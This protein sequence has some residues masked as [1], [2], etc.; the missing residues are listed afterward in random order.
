MH[1]AAGARKGAD[2][3][4]ALQRIVCPVDFSDCSRRALEHAAALARASY[5]ELIVLHV[6]SVLSVEDLLPLSNEVVAR[7]TPT[8][9]SESCAGLISRR[10]RLPPR[11]LIV[12]GSRHHGAIDRLVFGSHAH[13]VRRHA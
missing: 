4:I 3:V 12:L 2:A 10:R 8:A 13:A 6:Y 11:D 1:S 5:S 9:S 7:R